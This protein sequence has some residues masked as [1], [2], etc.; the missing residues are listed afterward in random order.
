MGDARTCEEDAGCD[1]RWWGGVHAHE[2]SLPDSGR[3]K[4]NDLNDGVRIDT[5]SMG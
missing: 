3:R 2:R 4:L 5:A 1:C